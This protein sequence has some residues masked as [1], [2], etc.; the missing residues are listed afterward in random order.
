MISTAIVRPY[1]N[2]PPLEVQRRAIGEW[3][4]KTELTVMFPA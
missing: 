4:I 3:V 2:R 1:A